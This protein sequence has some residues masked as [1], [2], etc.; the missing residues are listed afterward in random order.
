MNGLRWSCAALG[1]ALALGAGAAAAGDGRDA[2]SWDRGWRPAAAGKGVRLIKVH[3]GGGYYR[4]YYPRS[5]VVISGSLWW[6]LGYPYYAWPYAYPYAGWPY[7]GYAPP[8]TVYESVP[9]PAITA[10]P[11]APSWYYCPESKAYYPYVTE[12]PRGWENVPATPADRK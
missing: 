6:P 12:C 7:Y 10:Q 8:V 11:P 2:R 1:L 4:G 5:S 3:R 9:E